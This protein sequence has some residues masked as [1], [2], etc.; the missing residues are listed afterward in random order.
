METDVRLT[1]WHG[2]KSQSSR[3]G[4]AAKGNEWRIVA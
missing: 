1:L 3:H 2:V 4:A